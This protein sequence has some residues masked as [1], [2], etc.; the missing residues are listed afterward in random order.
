MDIVLTDWR[1]IFTSEH[2]TLDTLPHPENSHYTNLSLMALQHA[3]H[4]QLRGF[5]QPS[6]PSWKHLASIPSQTPFSYSAALLEHPTQARNIV[7]VTGDART[8]LHR[9][10][11][12][13]TIRH[14]IEQEIFA[15]ESE[16]FFP[17]GIAYKHTHA[18]DL[19]RDTIHEL[20]YIGIAQTTFE[21][22]PESSHIVR[23]LHDKKIHTKIISPMALRLSQ[24]IA[25]KLGIAASEDVCITGNNLASMSDNELRMYAPRVNIFS[26][27]EFA[28]AQR[29][30]RL[31]E[32]SG[33]RIIHHEFSRA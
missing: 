5:S 24:S 27:L 2:P 7:V 13:S 33:H 4:I 29:I 16:G 10:H 15:Q 11:I 32:E 3:P 20:T 6:K 8:V 25:R 14:T 1:G 31:L 17:I 30:T 22:I 18:S 21:I 28:D 9:C 26:E 19:S 12:A 23:K